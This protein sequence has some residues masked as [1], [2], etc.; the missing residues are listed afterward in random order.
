VRIIF[1]TI[2]YNQNGNSIYN[3]LINS[4]INHKH[5][6]VICRSNCEIEKNTLK[7]INENLHILDVQ[8]GNQFEKNLIKKGINMLLLERQFI[9]AIKKNL[10][11]YSFDL[12]LYA[13]PPI[14][15]NGVVEFCKKI[16]NAKSFLMLKDIFPQ[17]AIDLKMVK[18]NSFIHK[19]FSKKEEKLYR[20]S[21]YIGC[22]S[23]KNK[24]YLKK[25]DLSI[26]QK[27][28][29]FFNSVKIS[30]E[31]DEE[32]LTSS[33]YTTFLFGGNIG[34]PQN[35]N[36]LLKII[37]YLK[38]YPKSKF[39]I[40][41]KGTEKEVVENYAKTNSTNFKYIN[42]LE[43]EE[44]ENL[45]KSADIGLISLDP[46]FTIANIPSKLPTYYSLKK[47]VLAITDTCTDLKDMIL[48]NECGWWCDANDMENIINTIK[49]ICG[50]KEEQKRRGMNAY[51]Y[52][53]EYFDVEINVK[54]IENF[55]E[56][57]K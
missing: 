22:M 35:V 54:Q 20:I 46:R 39:I 4:L 21:D 52:L 3:D 56:E 13:T 6:I 17:N 50:S 31:K 33:Q 38:T 45:L 24:D 23:Q 5:Q 8:T 29:I 7:K 10:Q 57:L 48:E 32:I 34:K 43:K 47:P 37:D 2:S 36:Y 44:Y 55:M 30:D 42:F 27:S 49:E 16:F 14:S 15:L 28:H 51:N 53:K 1:L 11:S 9:K 26:Q 18:E 25:Y 40:V 12:V 41:G 19:F